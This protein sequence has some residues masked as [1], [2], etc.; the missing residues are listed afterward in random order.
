MNPALHSHETGNWRTP[1]HLYRQLDEE[2]SF[3]CDPCPF[4]GK[5]GPLFGED[6]LHGTWKGKRV[7][8]NPPYGPKIRDFLAKA[9]EATLAVFL[10]PARTD[11]RWFHEIVLPKAKEIRF[12]C[13]RLKFGD[14]KNSAPFP[15]MIVIFGQSGHR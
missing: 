8:C 14:A 5:V 9:S 3:N 7:F 13:G 12:I 15:S 2:L 1:L 6:G 11:T 4:Q 10:I